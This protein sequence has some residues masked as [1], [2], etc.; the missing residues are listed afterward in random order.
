[1]RFAAKVGAAIRNLSTQVF[2]E[3][4]NLARPISPSLHSETLLN[5][6]ITNG[7]AGVISL[8]A[9]VPDLD[10][11]FVYILGTRLITGSPQRRKWA[12]L[13][14]NVSDPATPVYI[15]QSLLA[16]RLLLAGSPITSDFATPVFNPNQPRLIDGII[17][18]ANQWNVAG[19]RYDPPLSQVFVTDI[20]AINADQGA[21]QPG[22]TGVSEDVT[23]PDGASIGG[24][25]GV[26]YVGQRRYQDAGDTGGANLVAFSL[27]GGVFVSSLT[28]GVGIPA[29]NQDPPSITE[30][31]LSK[32]GRYLVAQL[33]Y[34][35]TVAP[36]TTQAWLMLFDTTDP[37][38]P[39]LL[40][41]VVILRAG[42]GH[43]TAGGYIT[44]AGFL[45]MPF[46]TSGDSPGVSTHFRVYDLRAGTLTQ[47]NSFTYS[48]SP[49]TQPDSFL[50][51][52]S[53]G[54]QV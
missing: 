34:R 7:D 44:N 17:Y 37:L 11:S 33:T 40:D 15:E 51:V 21:P 10:A 2:L 29:S 30:I 24:R 5:T 19:F 32:N 48:A 53:K 13:I 47:V 42:N 39:S 36:V 49:G 25:T 31:L 20:Q 38:A 43:P 9:T 22:F 12:L 41:Q 1:M 14:Y 27:P 50:A 3:L 35:P 4:A 16:S 23:I 18:L 54:V 45:Y 26:L 52:N 28:L 6:A 46:D 8:S